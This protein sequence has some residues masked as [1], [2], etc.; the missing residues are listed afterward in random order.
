[1]FARGNKRRLHTTV[2]VPEVYV[3]TIRERFLHSLHVT[4]VCGIVQV[5]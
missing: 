2:F 3:R 1:M 4:S 5:F